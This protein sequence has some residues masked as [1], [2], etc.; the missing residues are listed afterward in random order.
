[1]IA[2]KSVFVVLVLTLVLSLVASCAPATPEVVEKE[3][4]VEKLV[5]ETVEV[6]KEVVVIAT[7]VPPP[8]PE[9]RL[10]IV[11]M[12]LVRMD[13]LNMFTNS[14]W[15]PSAGIEPIMQG[16]TG[17]DRGMNIV[18][19]LAKS[20]DV[21]DDGLT[22]TFHLRE[23]KFSD[24]EPFTAEDV[25]F[26]IDTCKDPEVPCF[27][28]LEVMEEVEIVDEHTVRLHLSKSYSPLLT[29]LMDVSIL[30]E[31]ILGGGNWD[32]ANY[33]KFPVAIGP[34][35]VTEHAPDH[36]TYETNEYYWGEPL[37]T[38]KFIVKDVVS[39]DMRVAQ[40]LSGDIDACFYVAKDEAIVGA[41]GK[42][43]YTGPQLV[44]IDFALNLT[45]PLLQ[46]KRVRQALA[47]A[48]DKDPI[49]LAASK[50][51]GV[52][53]HSWIPPSHAF[54]N[55]DVTKYPYDPEKARELLAEAGWEDHDGDGILD[56]DGEPFAFT[57]IYVGW[58]DAVGKDMALPT[59]QY[60]K[61]IGLDVSVEVITDG[62][63]FREIQSNMT[64]DVF[65]GG[66][67][68]GVDPIVGA[69]QFITG[70]SHAYGYSSPEF[71]RLK[72]EVATETDPEKRK[73]IYFRMQDIL[74]EDLPRMF[75]WFY[76][77]GWMVDPDIV[78]VEPLS[79]LGTLRGTMY[80]YWTK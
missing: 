8:A 73:E 57:I 26:T 63:L 6:V 59:Q 13:N 7:P 67:D 32:D 29:L 18:P 34:W 50:G 43:M 65:T 39:Y 49:T 76:S 46:D 52:V 51:P 30:P 16:L 70:S 45:N 22:W 75:M 47:Y 20:W 72:E 12:D 21:S 41:A 61:A 36:L 11:G 2:K 64:F 10:I 42:K 58:S 27:L 4:V 23:A 78:G 56:K 74:A 38:K 44:W 9:E 62:T 24:G 1:M 79:P 3:V 37:K 77:G 55:P 25:K 40:L 66:W 31:H 17:V 5:V 68:V 60:W 14:D 15:W 54:Y 19:L 71:D 69:E 80:W 33:S 28:D 35:K 53:A 48:I